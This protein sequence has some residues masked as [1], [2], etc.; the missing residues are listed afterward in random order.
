MHLTHEPHRAGLPQALAKFDELPNS[1]RVRAPVVAALHGV[2]LATVWRWTKSGLLP[3]PTKDGP[4]T[5]T[6]AVGDLRRHRAEK[7]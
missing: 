3:A 7:A 6:W 2:S 1:A 4:N 5:T